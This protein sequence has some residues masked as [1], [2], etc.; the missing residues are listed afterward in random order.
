M[1]TLII[2]LCLGRCPFCFGPNAHELLLGRR[3]LAGRRGVSGRDSGR[4]A[5]TPKCN[6][7]SVTFLGSRTS[8][9]QNKTYTGWL[10]MAC[11]VEMLG[12][13]TL[14]LRFWQ[15]PWIIPQYP[16]LPASTRRPRLFLA[17]ELARHLDAA[18]AQE[19]A[20]HGLGG[21]NCGGQLERVAFPRHV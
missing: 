15:L 3:G 10:V 18:G 7:T 16:R 9:D 20:L 14:H 1:W 6:F 13:S 12:N 19:Q 21:A 17:H 2:N 8:G 11:L 4:P 5:K